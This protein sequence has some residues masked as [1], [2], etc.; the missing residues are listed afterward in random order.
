VTNR[1]ETG[2]PRRPG[3]PDQHRRAP[4]TGASFAAAGETEGSAAERPEQRLLGSFR[5]PATARGSASAAKVASP[6]I[7]QKRHRINEARPENRGLG[8]GQDA[9]QTISC[10][11]RS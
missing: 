2:T 8:G 7:S 4:G 9:C 1:R 5:T 3:A 6:T 11:A 10:S